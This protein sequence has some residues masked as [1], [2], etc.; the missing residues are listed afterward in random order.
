[1]HCSPHACTHPRP[2]RFTW[3][4]QPYWRSCSARIIVRV[5]AIPPAG[6]FLLLL[7]PCPAVTLKILLRYV[8][9]G[10]DGLPSTLQQLVTQSSPAT[11]RSTLEPLNTRLPASHGPSSSKGPDVRHRLRERLHPGR[12]RLLMKQY[13]LSSGRRHKGIVSCECRTGFAS[14]MPHLPFKQHL[15]HRF[16]RHYH[17][18]FVFDPRICA[19][20]FRILFLLGP[21]PLHL[22]LLSPKPHLPWL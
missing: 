9:I 11:L 17:A 4:H 6:I 3:P 2:S 14:S 12:R 20:S 18:G 15:L 21:T 8:L 10:T 16:A 1:M 5:S 19:C 13:A 7:L 22:R